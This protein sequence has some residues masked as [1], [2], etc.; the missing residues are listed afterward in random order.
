MAKRPKKSDLPAS[1]VR[2]YLEP[3][4]IVL[5]SGLS[6]PFRPQD[7]VTGST[8]RCASRKNKDGTG[9]RGLSRP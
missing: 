7:S 9:V 3:G 1:G 5:V 6:S 8:C 4:S 2:R